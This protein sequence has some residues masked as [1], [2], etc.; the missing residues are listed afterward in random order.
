MSRHMTDTTDTT[1]TT[2]IVRTQLDSLLDRVE[3]PRPT[4]GG[5]DADCR[6]MLPDVAQRMERYRDALQ[7]ITLLRLTCPH[8]CDAANT[9]LEIA[10][11]ALE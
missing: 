2:R 5:L 1:D 6:R 11:E 8:A 9:A 7:R 10:R 4:D 3:R